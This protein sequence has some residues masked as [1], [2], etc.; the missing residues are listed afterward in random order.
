MGKLSSQFVPAPGLALPIR[1]REVVGQLE[2]RWQG[3][4]LKSVP[5]QAAQ[6]VHPAG[7]V[8]RLWHRVRAWL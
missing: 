3:R 5:V 4:L 2:L 6:S 7:L 1:A 8:T